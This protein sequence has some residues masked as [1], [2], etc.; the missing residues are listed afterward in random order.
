MFS[1]S[2]SS[3][4]LTYHSGIEYCSSKK[5]PPLF[6][7]LNTLKFHNNDM[8]R[9]REVFRLL[10]QAFSRTTEIQLENEL[11]VLLCHEFVNNFNALQ[12]SHNPT[13]PSWLALFDA[14]FK[15]AFRV[16]K[17]MMDGHIILDSFR[18]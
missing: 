12:V 2:N 10:Y 4:K 16:V 7:V 15:A 13:D 18:P 17:R 3:L 9:A 6:I 8:C 5:S 11:D 1:I 14:T